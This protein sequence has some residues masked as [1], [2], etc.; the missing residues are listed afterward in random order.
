MG[1]KFVRQYVTG[2]SLGLVLVSRCDR[3]PRRHQ[4]PLAALRSGEPV[5][6]GDRALSRHYVADQDGKGALSLYYHCPA[7]F[8][9]CGHVFSRLHEDFLA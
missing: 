9:G 1:R 2:G 3:S 6:L 7:A 4:H 8:Y 5:A